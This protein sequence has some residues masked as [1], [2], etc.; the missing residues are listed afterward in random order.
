MDHIESRLIHMRN[1]ITRFSDAATAPLD[2]QGLRAQ[3]SLRKSALKDIQVIRWRL[4]PLLR[5]RCNRLVFLSKPANRR[6]RVSART[7]A[8]SARARRPQMT[9]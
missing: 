1:I 2:I 5:T 4:R 7:C 6:Q 3:I 9:A 8:K